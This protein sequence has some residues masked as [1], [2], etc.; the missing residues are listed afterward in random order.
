MKP[1]RP[2]QKISA[3]LDLLRFPKP[4]DELPDTL[5]LK[6]ASPL[7]LS[8]PDPDLPDRLI[9]VCRECKHWFLIDL[10]PDL[11]EGIISTLPEVQ[12]IRNLSHEGLR[13]AISIMSP[14]TTRESAP[15]LRQD[16]GP[17]AKP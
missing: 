15:K 13:E 16:D 6:C 10:I 9:G 5:C 11:G 8:Q 14:P 17:D 3:N 7:F 2:L 1:Q 4:V 12:V